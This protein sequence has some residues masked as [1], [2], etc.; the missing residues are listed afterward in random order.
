[1]EQKL[2]LGK[3]TPEPEDYQ[4]KQ[5]ALKSLGNLE[6]KWIL[7]SIYQKWT[8]KPGFRLPQDVFVCVWLYWPLHTLFIITSGINI[9]SSTLYRR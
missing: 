7:P 1:M 3:E 8:S 9:A 5:L 6:M 2:V 4:L